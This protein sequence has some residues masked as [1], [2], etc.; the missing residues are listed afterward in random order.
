M[1]LRSNGKPLRYQVSYSGVISKV[2][3]ELRYQAYL[4]GQLEQFDAAWR[5]IIERLRSD[6]WSFGEFVRSF[7]HLQLKLH[8]G[9]VYPLTVRFGI[10]EK[11]PLVIIAKV[12]FVSPS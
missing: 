7:P 6:P 1:T 8:V 11:L 2:I 10:H 3:D 4:T 12:I 9:S 5:S